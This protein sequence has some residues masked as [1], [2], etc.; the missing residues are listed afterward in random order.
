MA[1]KFYLEKGTILFF[2]KKKIIASLKI[3]KAN[4]ENNV[5]I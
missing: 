1:S 5:T 4:I 2:E 3:N